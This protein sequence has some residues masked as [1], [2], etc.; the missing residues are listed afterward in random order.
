MMMSSEIS[1]AASRE[2]R[3]AEAGRSARLALSFVC[4]LFAGRIRLFP[5]D[6]LAVAPLLAH[7][8]RLLFELTN[9]GVNGGEQIAIGA[10]ADEVV[11]MI[12]HRDFDVVQIPLV[13]QHNVGLCLTSP[14]VQHL[15]DFF[16]L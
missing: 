3:D 12:G 11:M 16:E 9:S 15:A 8:Q 5:R 10:Y 13:F 4:R 7:T 1:A 2:L 14:V 6:S